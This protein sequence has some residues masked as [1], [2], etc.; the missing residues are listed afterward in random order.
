MF[1]MEI[2]AVWRENYTYINAFAR[3]MQSILEEI[4]IFARGRSK[5]EVSKILFWKKLILVFK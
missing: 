2:T 5:F 4:N 3:R 1:V